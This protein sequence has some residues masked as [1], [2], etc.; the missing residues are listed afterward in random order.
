M[1]GQEVI[2]DTL[3]FFKPLNYLTL[4]NGRALLTN[5]SRFIRSMCCDFHF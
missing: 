3:T 4:P 5:M 2:T 1:A